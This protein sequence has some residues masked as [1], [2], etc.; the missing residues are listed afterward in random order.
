MMSEAKPVDDIE[1]V[2]EAMGR[3]KG[4]TDYVTESCKTDFKVWQLRYTSSKVIKIS[5]EQ[6]Q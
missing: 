1:Q 4:T 5:W 2:R 6:Q 3:L